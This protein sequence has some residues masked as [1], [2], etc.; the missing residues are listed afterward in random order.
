MCGIGSP[1]ML[2]STIDEAVINE[3]VINITTIIIAEMIRDITNGTDT[4][5]GELSTIVAVVTDSD[6]MTIVTKEENTMVESDRKVTETTT[7]RTKNG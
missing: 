6:G 7:K 5:T 1:R 3:V 4:T 2:D